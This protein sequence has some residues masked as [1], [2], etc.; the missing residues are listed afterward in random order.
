MGPQRE[1]AQALNVVL[2]PAL[3]LLKELPAEARV[4]HDCLVLT[5]WKFRDDHSQP[6]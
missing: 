4:P 6:A 5:L 2:G 3:E 1:L